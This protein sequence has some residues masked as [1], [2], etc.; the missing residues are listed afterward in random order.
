MR[1]KQ[2]VFLFL[3]CIALLFSESAFADSY[4]TSVDVLQ[5][6]AERVITELDSR[7]A[8]RFV[9]TEPGAK[10]YRK[11]PWETGDRQTVAVYLFRE[12]GTKEALPFGRRL[13]KQLG[14]AMDG[15][16]KF[17]YVLRDMDKFYDMKKRETDFMINEETAASVGRVLGA[18]YFLNGTYWQ[19][20][21]ETVIQAALWDAGNGN[22][23]PRSGWN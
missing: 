14:Q 15:S 20:G 2:I 7:A 3:V 5:Q 4:P 19:E 1:L 22:C 18:R 12:E 9:P 17:M 8:W 21:N 6:L 13:Q 23:S 16:D 11:I 10:E